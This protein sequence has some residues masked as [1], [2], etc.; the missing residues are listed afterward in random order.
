MLRGNGFHP[1]ANSDHMRRNNLPVG[2][3]YLITSSARASSVSGT[4][5]PSA[6]AVLRLITQGMTP[7]ERR[8]S[9]EPESSVSWCSSA[10]VGDSYIDVFVVGFVASLVSRLLCSFMGCFAGRF[11]SS[12][13]GSF[14]GC[15]SDTSVMANSICQHS[16]PV[17]QLRI[18]RKGAAG[19]AGQTGQTSTRPSPLSDDVRRYRALRASEAR[20]S[21]TWRVSTA[22]AADPHALRM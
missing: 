2:R 21:P 15:Y 16:H 4:V 14:L 6:L 13:A 18:G 20:S 7:R 8:L 17:N 10:N 3:G 19:K 22:G 11:I 9:G 12:F 5:M 1:W